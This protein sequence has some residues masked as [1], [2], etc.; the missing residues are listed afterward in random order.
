M[1]LL[2]YTVIEEGFPLFMKNPNYYFQ[3]KEKE[4]KNPL[5]VLKIHLGFTL[6]LIS[7]ST[8][9]EDIFL[10][11]LFFVIIWFDNDEQNEQIPLKL[12]H[13]RNK[14]AE[15]LSEY[16]KNVSFSFFI[17]KSTM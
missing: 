1:K 9:I 14:A 12:I 13:P 8:V 5:K 17:H 10:E 2:K 3:G 11:I 15:A 16:G 7:I 6:N 4:S